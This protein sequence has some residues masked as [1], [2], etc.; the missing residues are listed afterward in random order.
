MHTRRFVRWP[1]LAACFLTLCP[2]GLCQK[3]IQVF[4]KHEGSDSVGNQIAFAIRESLRRSEGSSLGDD[5]AKTV[6]ELVTA[7]TVQNGGASVVSLVI[8]KKGDS[9]VLQL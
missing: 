3:K 2:I 1:C 4:V 8:I 6:I 9:P 5:Q 7:G